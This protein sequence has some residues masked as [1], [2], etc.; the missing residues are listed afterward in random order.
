M[1]LSVITEVMRARIF[2]LRGNRDFRLFCSYDLDLNLDPM[3]LAYTNLT[4]IAPRDTQM[5]K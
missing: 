3:S 2:T 4:R 5:C 1:A